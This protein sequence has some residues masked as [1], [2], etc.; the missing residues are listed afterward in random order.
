MDCK[1]Q[2]PQQLQPMVFA[3]QMGFLMAQDVVPGIAA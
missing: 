1:G 3:V 2:E